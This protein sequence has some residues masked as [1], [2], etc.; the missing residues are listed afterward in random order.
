[1]WRESNLYIDGLIFAKEE[2]I[3]YVDFIKNLIENNSIV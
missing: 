1:M 2:Q 3:I